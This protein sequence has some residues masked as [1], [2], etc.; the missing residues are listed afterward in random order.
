MSKAARTR[1]LI[2]SL[3]R[4][5]RRVL[6]A[7][8]PAVIALGYVISTSHAASGT[9]YLAPSTA[10][11]ANGATVTVQVRESSGADP[12][13]AVQA[14][15]SYDATKLDFVNIDSTAS[16]FATEAEA[17]G[18]AGS[19]RI[20]RGNITALTGDQ[21]VTNVTFRSKITTGS[22]AVDISAGSAIVRSTDNVNI[23]ITSTGGVYGPDTAA[24]SVPM[25]LSSSNVTGTTAT[26][27]WAGSTD[28]VGV[29]GYKVYRDG[30]LRSTQASLSFGD[31]GLAMS[32]T[33]SYAVSAIDAAG[34][35]SVKSTALSVTTKDTAAP[36]VPQ[37]TSI[38]APTYASITLSWSTSTD[39]GGSGLKGYKVYRNGSTT[40]IASPSVASYTDSTVSGS[41]TYSYVVSAVDN[42][43]N[44]SAKSTAAAVTTPNPPDTAAPSAPTSLHSTATSLTSISLAWNASA[45]NVGVIGYRLMSGSTVVANTTALSFTQSSLTPGTSHTYTVYAYDLAG[46][47]SIASNAVTVST[48]PLKSG[49]LNSDNA[50][51]IFD[52][53]ILLS[54]WQTSDAT[55]D[56][57]KDGTVNI[58]DLSILMTGWGK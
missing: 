34:N 4:F 21:L 20:A 48:P 14:N 13:N 11:V 7:L 12:V 28:N 19:V 41:T 10:I 51:N 27:S 25:S 58:F 49:D 37:V 30:V 35:E 57:N 2:S 56:I 15:L 3:K 6:F 5:D 43:G 8:L 46:N 36:S 22:A 54:H 9:L 47:T 23:L 50:V 40:A 32:T 45:D 24:P 31:T 33:Y 52:L 1:G 55:S 16:A 44:E 42:A 18:G 39:T 38:S 29:T 17:T 26:V 53:S